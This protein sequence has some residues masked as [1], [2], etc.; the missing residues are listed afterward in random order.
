ERRN[1]NSLLGFCETTRCRRQVLL[2]HFGE[3][4]LDPCGNCDTCTL[5][6]EAWDGTVA[7]QKALSCVHRTGE[8]FGVAYLID[9]LLGKESKRILQFRHHTLST[10]GIGKDLSQSQWH[11]VFRQLPAFGFLQVDRESYGGLKLHP[12]SRAVLRGEKKVNFRK[13][14]ERVK[15]QQK[16]LQGKASVSVDF[17]EADNQKL[18]EALKSYRRELAQRLKIPPYM[19]FHDSTLKEMV[20]NKPKNLE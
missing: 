1:L 9:V 6:V 8:R 7:A 15:K 14:P 5:P 16:T 12:D 19:I 13:D 10:F 2:N 3:T 20:G 17:D 11:S 18:W 4:A